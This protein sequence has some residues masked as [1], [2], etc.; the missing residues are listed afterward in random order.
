MMMMSANV[1]SEF[2]PLRGE[3]IALAEM[4]LKNMYD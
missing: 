2:T 1:Q 3:A 4:V